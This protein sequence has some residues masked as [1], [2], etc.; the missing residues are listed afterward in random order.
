MR[1]LWYLFNYNGWFIKFGDWLE[2]LFD[3]LVIF[4]YNSICGIMKFFIVNK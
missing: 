3:F 4:C 1:I 2:N